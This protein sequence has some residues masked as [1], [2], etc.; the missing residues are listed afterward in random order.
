MSQEQKTLTRPPDRLVSKWKTVVEQAGIDADAPGETVVRPK[1]EDQGRAQK[2][3]SRLP[4]LDA[5]KTGADFKMMQTLGQGGM[6]LVRLAYQASLNRQVAVKSILAERTDVEAVRDLLLESRITGMLEHPNIVPVHALGV[7]DDGGPMMVMKRV[8]GVSWQDALDDPSAMPAPFCEGRDR[9]EDHLQILLQVCNAVQFAHS[10]QIIHCD[11]KPDNVMLGDYGE[12]YLLDWGVAVSISR[13][14][15]IDL[16]LVEDVDEVRGT[17]AYIAP[18]LAVGRAEQIDE[19]S[20]VYLL[21]SILHQLI[22]GRARHEGPTVMATLIKAYRS[23]PVEYDEK[24]PSELAAICN[25]ATRAER[26]QRFRDVQSFRRE[27]VRFL[28][29]RES[30]RL[31]NEAKR[32]LEELELLMAVII[33][34][35][36]AQDRAAGADRRTAHLYQLFSECRFGFEQALT[37]WKD[38]EQARRGKRQAL[39][40]MIEFEIYQRDEKAADL[41]LNELSEPP[42]ALVE[43]LEELRRS[44][45][46]EAAEVER[47]R[48]I[49]RN[50]DLSLASR[51][52]AK[53]CLLLGLLFGAVPF[54]QHWM[55]GQGLASLE[56]RDYAIQYVAI[57]VGAGL[58]VGAMRQR[59]FKNAINGRIVLSV[60]IILGGALIM[61]VLGFLLGLDPAGCIALEN[62]L[63]AFGLAMLATSI[64][65]RL[66]PA[67]V[68]FLGGAVGGAIFPEY[69]LPFDG[70]SNAA[71]L[72]L[73]AWV[74]R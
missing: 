42:A 34:E 4:R 13:D 32:R 22:T 43:Q 71:A 19:R 46:D 6:G 39:Q 69:I 25:R 17:P 50:V 20:D 68:A 63:F 54:I 36:Q 10:R 2:R 33:D 27:I 31:V 41:L 72:W 38:N 60:F 66:W 65:W 15:A 35:S 47:H 28:Q 73:I 70:A 23:D 9:L 18:E 67:A 56:F 21:G 8:E 29:H 12:V 37:V 61:R 24:V 44:R 55:I 30:R 49:S 26:E 51:Q 40:K 45:K 59:L 3:L 7:D 14:R 53:M 11:L 58:I 16:P 5:A 62:G 1:P 57:V 64:D 74:W 52:R 48:R